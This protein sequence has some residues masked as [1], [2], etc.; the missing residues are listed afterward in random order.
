HDCELQSVFVMIKMKLGA[1][2]SIALGVVT[3]SQINKLID[4]RG[5]KA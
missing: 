2:S 1:I 3:I 4:D 5:L